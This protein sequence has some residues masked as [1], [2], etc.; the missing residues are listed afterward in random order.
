MEALKRSAASR[1]PVDVAH[2]LLCSISRAGTAAARFHNPVGPR[3][4]CGAL[5]KGIQRH[6]IACAVFCRWLA[7]RGRM[8]SQP[9]DDAMH[10]LLIHMAGEPDPIGI[11]AA[12][13]NGVALATYATLRAGRRHN[14]RAPDSEVCRRHRR[15]RVD[16]RQYKTAPLAP[17]L[18]LSPP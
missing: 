3:L 9:E 10:G 1:P 12:V 7:E 14:P 6:C 18:T 15:A 8:H 2:C 4:H 17:R 13:A 11:R 16:H 5:A